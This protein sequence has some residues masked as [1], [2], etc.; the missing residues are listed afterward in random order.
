VDVVHGTNFVVPPTRKAARVVT[1]HDLTPV[2]FPEL[3]NAATAVF[4]K[5]VRRAIETGAWVHTP[6]HFVAAEVIS[7]FGADPRKVR[8]VHHGVPK[9][10]IEGAGRRYETEEGSLPD[11]PAGCSRFILAVGTVEPRKD[12]PRLVQAFNQVAGQFEDLA[13]VVV[14]P[15]GGGASAFDSAVENSRWSDRIVRLGYATDAQLHKA[16]SSCAVLAYP[17]IYEGFGFPPLQAL[18]L[19]T[20]VVATAAGALPEV[21]GDAADLVPPG[22][23][24]AL[25]A[26]LSKVLASQDAPVAVQRRKARASLFTWEKCADGLAQLY[27]DC[28]AAREK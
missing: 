5:L 26:A 1:V 20:P 25:A 8:V 3:R 15:D 10:D 7:E 6:S 23:T 22:D 12:L 28:L 17:S 21:L 14:G 13:L 2:R 4:P 24:D 27:D 19:G 18:A 9:L 16:L 11:L